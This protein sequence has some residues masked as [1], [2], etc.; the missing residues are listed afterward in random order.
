MHD[1]KKTVI[2]TGA[3]RGIGRGI[4]LMLAEN[5]CVIAAAGT[6]PEGEVGEYI[7]ELKKRSPESVYITADISK[8]QDCENLVRETEER[9]KGIDFLV[10]NAGIAPPVRSD[11]LETTRESFDL[12]LAVNL[13]GTFFLTQKA[14]KSMIKSKGQ[15]MRAIVNISSVSA[16]TSSTNR[17]EYCISKAGVSMI[18]ALFADRLAEY[19][20]NVY[21]IRPGIIKTD[22]TACVLDKYEA[23]IGGGLLP[24]GRLGQPEDVAKPVLA[25][26]LG[27]LPYCTGEV[28]EADG[29]FHIR[30]L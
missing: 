29:G 4:S 28:I 25:I 16:Y 24:M 10:N 18:T 11:I 14:A 3:S 8:D 22:M 6:R 21:E 19:G 15:G 13:K 12:L 9:F 2:V 17:A 7:G 20:I 27:L 26:V 30:R 5:G 1:G 23:M